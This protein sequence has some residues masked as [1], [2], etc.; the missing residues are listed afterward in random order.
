MPNWIGAE[1]RELNEQ[2][3]LD[4]AERQDNPS[5]SMAGE[6][7]YDEDYYDEDYNDTNCENSEEESDCLERHSCLWSDILCTC[8]CAYEEQFQWGAQPMDG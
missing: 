2:E 4:V 1:T 7:Y 3:L 8:F 6:D 5:G